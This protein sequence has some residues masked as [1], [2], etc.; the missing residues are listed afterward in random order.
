[1][2]SKLVKVAATRRYCIA[3]YFAPTLKLG[4]LASV[5]RADPLNFQALALRPDLQKITQLENNRR[6]EA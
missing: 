4:D 3:Q 5:H 1:M 6:Y 2:T